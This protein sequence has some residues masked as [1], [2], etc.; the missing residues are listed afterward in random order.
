MAEVVQQR[1]KKLLEAASE[2]KEVAVR[3]YLEAGGSPNAIVNVMGISAPLLCVAII[4][5]HDRGCE[6]TLQLL[7]Q[8][9]AVNIEAVSVDINGTESTA[10]ILAA[11]LDCC[12]L[13]LE[14]LLQKGADVCRQT[15][16]TRMS[17]LHKAAYTGQAGKCKLLLSA[18]KR[19]LHL[20]DCYGMT[21]LSDAVHAGYLPVVK[22][23]L[24]E[25]GADIQYRDLEGNTLLHL[26]KRPKQLPVLRYLL[27]RGGL[28]I[29]AVNQAHATPIHCAAAAERG[30]AVVQALL[31]AGADPSIKDCNGH[32]AL[33]SANRE[34]PV[35]SVALLL[36]APGMHTELRAAD[37]VTLLMGC[38][39][40][41]EADKAELLL[42][43]G[44]AVN[45]VNHA[46]GT[47]LHLVALY[48]SAATAALLLQYGADVHARDASG[49]TP[50]HYAAGRPSSAL[51]E[52][53]LSAV[54]EDLAELVAND[55]STLLH[56]AAASTESMQLLLLQHTA[57][58]A[59][60]LDALARGCACCGEHTA[61]MKCSQPG[62][63]QFLLAAG[64][65]A[66]KTTASGRTALHV[67]AAHSY[68]AAMVC[69]LIKAGVDLLAEDGEGRTAAQVAAAV[70]NALT[71]TLLTRAAAG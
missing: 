50:L 69:L 54:S 70:G 11:D 20:C 41:G 2:C 21:P 63:L 3:R 60:V 61:L 29:N 55:G 66:K 22:L 12:S 8:H 35:A 67:A 40:N 42:E 25:H 14:A 32:N 23:L 15:P 52:V 36:S 9:D 45:A 57:A 44:A 38:C 1:L 6:G 10:L 59:P 43:R 71:A 46:N 47:V 7:L 31:Q 65:D 24:E 58:V 62:P 49:C 30:T 19:A 17:A 48:G 64:A 27:A 37:G 4:N 5:H 51:L 68:P 33:F 39:L 18:D 13:P 28:D 53:L 26:I 34:G 56:A 16:T